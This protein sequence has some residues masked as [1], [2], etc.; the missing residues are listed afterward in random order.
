MKESERPN[1]IRKISHAVDAMATTAAPTQTAAP[2]QS[3]PHTE[4]TS[5]SPSV[6]GGI[7]TAASGATSTEADSASKTSLNPTTTAGATLT[8]DQSTITTDATTNNTTTSET[9]ATASTATDTK[10]IPKPVYDLRDPVTGEL[11]SKNQQKK[12]RRQQEWD[13]KKEDRRLGRKDKVKAKKERIRAERDNQPPE[14]WK[15]KR[16]VVPGIQV[17]LTLLI[18]CN[19]DDKM[20]DNERISLAG[21]ITR[22]YSENKNAKFRTHVAVSSFGGKLKERFDGVLAKHYQSWK[23]TNFIEEDFVHAAEEAKTWMADS[24]SGGKLKSVFE[25]YAATPEDAAK[26]KEGGEVIYL[27]SDSDYT[28]TELKPY[29]TYIIGGLVDK[30]R[31]KGICH[32]RAVEKGVKTARLPI[33]DYLDMASRKVLATNHV[34]EIMLRWLELGDWGEAFMK[35]IPKRKGGTLKG[36]KGDDDEDVF[37]DRH[38]EEDDYQEGGAENEEDDAEAEAG[39]NDVEMRGTTGQTQNDVEGETSTAV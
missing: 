18:D 29:S 15:E 38:A 12:L 13:A 20:M 22:S 37:E 36:A 3:N 31:E 33:G 21:Q 5:T 14:A 25:K 7:E 1:K 10:R 27:S 17:P 39:A 16:V 24:K 23:G 19:F 32:R 35:V 9:P 28:L 8:Q 6:N 4:I 11:L 2:E 34:V 26:A 30:N